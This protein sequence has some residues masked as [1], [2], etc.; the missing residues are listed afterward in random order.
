[1]TDGRRPLKRREFSKVTAALALGAGTGCGGGSS[2]DAPA[3]TPVSVAAQ[4]VPPELA[5]QPVKAV[6]EPEAAAPPPPGAPPMGTNLSGMEWAVAGLRFSPSSRPNVDFTVPRAADVAY[7]AS[8]GHRKNRLPIQW[9]LLQPM[10]HDTPANAAA[11][12]AI[13]QPGQFH[14]AYASCITGVL[15]AHAAVGSRCIIDLHNYC[16]YQDFRFQPDGSVIG[17]TV[18]SDPLV[19]AYTRDASQVRTRIFALAPGAT[20]T[21]ANFTDFWTRAALK[22][23]DHPGFGGYG[24]MNEP[25]DLPRDGGIVAWNEEPQVR[26]D[27][28]LLIWPE[29]AKAA[30]AAI[31]ALDATG[32]IYL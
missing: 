5:V 23:K 11:R 4:P 10:L 21:V 13:G 8:T 1:M 15:D 9:E 2:S 24:L 25:Y 29:F 18:P 30:I 31:R 22:W 20:L 27:E 6:P 28:S 32:T 17:L 26:D 19:R 7:L 16:R 3:G 14:A 12:A